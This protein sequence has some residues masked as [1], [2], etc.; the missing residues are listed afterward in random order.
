MNPMKTRDRT[1]LALRS[2]SAL[3]ALM[4]VGCGDQNPTGS[5]TPIDPADEP[6]LYFDS[7]ASP[8]HSQALIDCDVV[9]S[10][11][12][13]ACGSPQAPAGVGSP[14]IGGR[15][16]HARLI[17]S[18]LAYNSG[19][20]VLS[21][22]MAVQNLL[23]N[24]IGTSVDSMSGIT[25]FFRAGPSRTGGSGPVS[26]INP[27]GVAT[28]TAPN[29]PYFHYPQKL[30]LLQTSATRQWLMS[31]HPNVTSLRFRIYISAEIL[32]VIVF[33]GISG[34]SNRD[35]WR[36]AADGSDLVRLTSAST[37]ES[38][39]TAAQNTVIFTRKIGSISSLW[40]V[41]LSGGPMTQVLAGPGNLEFPALNIQGTRVAYT[42]D[43]SGS[44]RIWTRVLAQ[45]YST[46]LTGPSTEQWTIETSP[47]WDP[48]FTS[49]ARA[50][51]VSN[52]TGRAG[53]YRRTIAVT[54]SAVPLVATPDINIDGRLNHQGTRLTFASDRNAGF[55]EIYV[56]NNVPGAPATRLTTGDATTLDAQPTFLSDGSI[57][58][59]RYL[60]GAPRLRRI[61]P[62]SGSVI[63]I[64]PPG[65][66]PRNPSGVPLWP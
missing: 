58:H 62:T 64:V 51:Y 40:S 52:F 45:S 57:A 46:P 5:D 53:I 10:P 66:A 42:S 3:L 20:Q 30:S 9:M 26:L 44:H 54:G 1:R 24:Q 41:P 50:V 22:D 7:L 21:M 27:D 35:I 16:L 39:P 65:R 29:Q 47:T 23:V 48:S 37:D 49:P 18:N 34:G 33:D 25:P 6:V 31:V 61:H 15:G 28:F 55:A 59:T 8:F 43:V 12:S 4:I 19:T 17:P 32:P 14:Q 13:I 60:S 36:V 56:Q 2:L 63:T 11:L 38:Q